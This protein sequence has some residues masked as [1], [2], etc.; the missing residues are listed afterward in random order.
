VWAFDGS[1]PVA[2]VFDGLTEDLDTHPLKAGELPLACGQ[3]FDDIAEARIRVRRC[4]ALD[5]AVAGAARV[6]VGDAWKWVRK[7]S[8]VDISPLVAA[9][10]GLWVV[11]DV[12]ETLDS[13]R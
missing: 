10:V 4:K 3:I 8:T 9:T 2:S 6:F 11:R 13:V 5:V 7:N 12:Y 1:G